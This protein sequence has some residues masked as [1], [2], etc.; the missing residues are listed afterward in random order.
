MLKL[1]RTYALWKKGLC[2]A[3]ITFIAISTTDKASA[4]T[5][6]LPP[7]LKPLPA[8]KT[9][10]TAI[11][12]S[13]VLRNATNNTVLTA[14]KEHA[15]R[16][17]NTVVLP[18][19]KPATLSQAPHSSSSAY[20]AQTAQEQKSNE[21]AG[22]ESASL[23]IPK[24]KPLS[25]GTNGLSA[26]DAA[27][28]KHIFIHQQNG[29]WDKADELISQ[30]D[31][32]LLR[33]HVLYQRYMHPAAYRS[34]FDELRGWLDLYA[35]HPGAKKIYKLALGRMPSNFKGTLKKPR[36]GRILQ[37]V[38]PDLRDIQSF[39]SYNHIDSGRSKSAY[40]KISAITKKVDN[41]LK[42]GGPTAA[43]KIINAPYNKKIL[44]VSEY[45][46]LK[47]QIAASY[48][49]LGYWEQAKKIAVQS[50]TPLQGEVPLGGW[51]A[52]LT[53]WKDGQ[54]GPAAAYF[55]YAAR[56]GEASPWTIAAAAYWAARA[57]MRTSNFGDVSKWLKVG[58]RYPRTFYGI[59]STKALGNAVNFN[60]DT[61][62]LTPDMQREIMKRKG[63]LRAMALMQVEQVHLAEEELKY[64]HPGN[65]KKLQ[66]AL[67]AYAYNAQLPAYQMRFASIFNKAEGNFYDAALFP[68]APWQKQRKTN[69]GN[70]DKA[71]IN[72]FI[73]QESRFRSGAENP[74]GATG[75]MQIM[76]DTA[77]Y[78]MGTKRFSGAGRE[79]LKD[80][81]LNMQ[82]GETYIYNLLK[83]D[84]IDND[85]FS[86]A[87]AYNAGPGNLRRWKSERAAQG[88]AASDDPLFFIET[89]PM[90]ETRSFVERVMTNIWIY[91]MRLNQPTP[92]LDAVAQGHWPLYIAMDKDSA[93]NYAFINTQG[94]L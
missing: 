21:L 45:A 62:D 78:V 15:H 81:Q 50:I 66:K 72:A 35:D 28:Y 34:S 27:L 61:P 76:P 56:S 12:F 26:K 2:L 4:D 8:K 60:W 91:R 44:S 86:L 83:Q 87:I 9:R 1:I 57:H 37:G 48:L 69:R 29:E 41:L 63:A 32:Y 31:D 94:N 13:D 16:T 38:H 24:T 14:P 88:L 64:I 39:S 33:G 59:L 11:S 19:H 42:R 74:S 92:S 65:N 17:A 54:F 25:D 82:I 3:T 58:A 68:I 23:P 36:L 89:F 80:P 52:G 18:P 75:L 70:V 73:R 22:T 71:V 30:L 93:P 51:V 20:N 49:H 46:H 6:L 77:N 43:L 67:L 7:P 90:S 84:G 5:T 53:H 85:L 79:R 47:A 55:E 10:S 40:R